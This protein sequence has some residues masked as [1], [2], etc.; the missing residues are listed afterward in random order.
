MLEI[1]MFYLYSHMFTLSGL[2]S[3]KFES[4]SSTEQ[5]KVNIHHTE[6]V[7]FQI[8]KFYV[9]TIPKIVYYSIKS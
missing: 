5:W 9:I 6:Q 8:Q 3:L 1:L 4:L 7:C 2:K